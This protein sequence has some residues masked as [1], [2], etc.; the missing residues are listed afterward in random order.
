MIDVIASWGRLVRP[1]C[2]NA[3]IVRMRSGD[4]GVEPALWKHSFEEYY[5]NED[6]GASWQ[7]RPLL[8][9]AFMGRQRTEH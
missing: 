5:A 1:N 2:L 6:S 3:V 4:L 9:M 7:E 8:P